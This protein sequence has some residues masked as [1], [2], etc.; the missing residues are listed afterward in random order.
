MNGKAKQKKARALDRLNHVA[1]FGKKYR[2]NRSV[3]KGAM[4]RNEEIGKSDQGNP[5]K[6]KEKKIPRTRR[7]N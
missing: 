5:Q 7:N 3:M 6:T 4:G 2:T 1:V